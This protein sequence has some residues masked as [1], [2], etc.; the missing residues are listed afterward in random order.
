M[1]SRS[2]LHRAPR[3][4]L[5]RCRALSFFTPRALL[6][7]AAL[8]VAC[9]R[10]PPP[11]GG[12][13]D[14]SGHRVTLSGPARRVVSLAPATTELLFAVGAGGQLVGRTAWDVYPPAARAVPS[15]GDGLAPNVEAIAARRPDLVIAYPSPTNLGAE[16]QLHDLAIP[17]FDLRTDRL[18]DVARGA[19]LLGKLTG[20][21]TRAAAMADTFAAALD[22]ARRASAA[23]SAADRPRVLLLSWS[24]PPIVIGGGSFQSELVTLAGATNVFGD[25]TQPSAQVSIETIAARDPDAVVSLGGG[26][27]SGWSTRP[28]WQAVRA[29]RER[30]FI[31]VTGSAFGHPSFRALAAVRELRAALRRLRR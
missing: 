28:E 12:M 22:S 5:E 9:T 17:V 19:R 11:T 15:V 29:V 25:L 6:T 27:D 31:S 7:L 8:G 18:D 14:D 26:V 13:T 21:A 2:M 3:H 23:Q 4:R 10:T 16:R 30:R 24:Q 1:G 20:H